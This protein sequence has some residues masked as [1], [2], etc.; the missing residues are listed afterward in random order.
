MI[1]NFGSRKA[2]TG[3]L[4]VQKKQLLRSL[5]LDIMVQIYEKMFRY[6]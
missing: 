4:T 5:Y 2:K 1:V 3:E 6:N